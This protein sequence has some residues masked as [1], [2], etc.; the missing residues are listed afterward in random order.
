M[1]RA[2]SVMSDTDSIQWKGFNNTFVT[3]TKADLKEALLLA[4]QLQTELWLKYSL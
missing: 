1:A 2:F 4:G 3:L